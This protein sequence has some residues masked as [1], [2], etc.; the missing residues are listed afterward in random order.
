MTP[1]P[2]F[3]GFDEIAVR[4]LVAGGTGAIGRH[5]AGGHWIDPGVAAGSVADLVPSSGDRRDIV[6]VRDVRPHA[7]R[8]PINDARTARPAP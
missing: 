1:R 3:T 7:V 6:V 2:T 5:P 8:R 4:V